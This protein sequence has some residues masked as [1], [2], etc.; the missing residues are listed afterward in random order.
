MDTFTNALLSAF[1]ALDTIDNVYS[2]AIQMRP[3][4]DDFTRL[5]GSDLQDERNCL[6]C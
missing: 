4:R 1:G 2:V 3:N 5:C 6:V